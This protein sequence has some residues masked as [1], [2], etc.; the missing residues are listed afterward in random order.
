MWGCHRLY[1]NENFLKV[2]N[3]EDS[4]F[5][6]LKAQIDNSVSRVNL[7][8]EKFALENKEI[9]SGGDFNLFL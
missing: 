8:P 3:D 2:K 9:I 7:I 1:Q 5:L 4:R 6:I